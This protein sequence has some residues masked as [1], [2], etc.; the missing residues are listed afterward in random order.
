MVHG[1]ERILKKNEIM[2]KK[3]RIKL[4]IGMWWKISQTQEL[5]HYIESSDT[6]C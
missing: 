4:E 6:S 3:K 1:H 5:K 2:E